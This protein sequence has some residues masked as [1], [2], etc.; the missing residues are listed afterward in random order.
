MLTLT[1]NA[2]HVVKAIIAQ[3]PET[4]GGG[5]RINAEESGSSELGVAVAPAPEPTDAVVEQDGARVFLDE[6]AT[7]ALADKVLDA[8]VDK[9]SSVRFD[10][11]QQQVG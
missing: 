5:L 1:E 10:I 9:D 6:N 8:E 7:A 2:S 3:T 4:D 11:G